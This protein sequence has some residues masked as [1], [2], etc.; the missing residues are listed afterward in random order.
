MHPIE[1]MNPASDERSAPTPVAS[2]SEPMPPGVISP[3]SPNMA[4]SQAPTESENS[5]KSNATDTCLT[6]SKEDHQTIRF[7]DDKVEKIADITEELDDEKEVEGQSSSKRL[8]LQATDN[9]NAAEKR[10]EPSGPVV[11]TSQLTETD[12][13]P[14]RVVTP[15]VKAARGR[16]KGRTRGRARVARGRKKRGS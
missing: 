6:D 1:N 9:R 16:G 12:L 7:V 5:E 13:E 4:G 3:T 2:I 15:P 11:E 14:E 10:D 8:K